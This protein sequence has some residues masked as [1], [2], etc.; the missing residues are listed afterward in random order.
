MPATTISI[1]GYHG[2]SPCLPA[3]LLKGTIM[4][5]QPEKPDPQHE[6]TPHPQH[7]SESEILV[8][9]QHESPIQPEAVPHPQHEVK[10]KPHP[11][12][13]K[14]KPHPQHE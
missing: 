4:T 6:A 8:N 1:S 11:Q 13:E 3:Q 2:G 12:H 14:H 9:P 10:H 7:E 5:S